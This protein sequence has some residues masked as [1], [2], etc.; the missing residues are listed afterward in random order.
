MKALAAAPVLRAQELATTPPDAIG[1]PQLA[2]LSP[3]EFALLKDLCGQ[4]VPALGDR[5]GAVEAGVPAF[6]DFLLSRSSPSQQNLYR[7]GLQ[8]WGT[9]S[10]RT[11]LTAFLEQPWTYAEPSDPGENFLRQLKDDVLRATFNSK[12]WLEGKRG[13]GTGYF[14]KAFD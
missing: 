14:W 6:L 10:K 13:A 7:S 5:P 1:E 11:A 2:F 4:I 12:Q 8:A 3:G 9:P